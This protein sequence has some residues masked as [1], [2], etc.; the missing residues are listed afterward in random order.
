MA[1]RLAVHRMQ[2]ERRY[3]DKLQGQLAALRDALPFDADKRLDKAA[4]MREAVQY[5]RHLEALN[6]TPANPTRAPLRMHPRV[7]FDM[8]GLH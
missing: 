5:I 8:G 2:V 4:V 6:G 7:A 1:A 3:R